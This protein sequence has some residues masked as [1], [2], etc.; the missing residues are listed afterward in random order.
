MGCG[1][2]RSRVQPR[3]VLFQSVAQSN[4]LAANVLRF[5]GLARCDELG[6]GEMEGFNVAHP[7]DDVCVVR[8]GD[9]VVTNDNF[10]NLPLC[11]LFT[12]DNLGTLPPYDMEA[13]LENAVWHHNRCLGHHGLDPLHELKHLTDVCAT[14]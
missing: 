3:V 10:G 6:G 8:A 4:T 1:C 14:S 12:N 13:S 2:C 11:D 5:E 7:T 9:D